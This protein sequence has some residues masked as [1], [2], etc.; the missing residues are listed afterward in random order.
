MDLGLCY[1]KGVKEIHQCYVGTDY[2]GDDGDRCFTAGC[3]V[4]IMWAA[5]HWVSQDRKHITYRV[6]TRVMW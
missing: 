4:T 1:T 2:G 6:L 3:V 5:V